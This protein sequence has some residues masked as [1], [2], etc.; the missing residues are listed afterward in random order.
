MMLGAQNGPNKSP[1]SISG[2]GGTG[3]G[4]DQL[5]G[6]SQWWAGPALLE[7]SPGGKCHFLH[8]LRDGSDVIVIV[9]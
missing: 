7:V 3:T 8:R 4:N 1:M 2:A 9:L 6:C 5:G